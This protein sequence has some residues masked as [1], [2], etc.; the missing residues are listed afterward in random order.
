MSKA[1]FGTPDSSGITSDYPLNTLSGVCNKISVEHGFWEAS[2]NILEKI[3]L[4]HTELSEAAE[5]YRQ[6]NFNQAA[7]TEELADTL[8][9][10]FDLSGHMGLDLDKAVN[11]KIE[12][13]KAR[14]FLHGKSR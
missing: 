8:I 10:I 2:T 14:K 1:I 12:I 4:V 11:D 7:F 13:N 9:R 3:C 5:E 6:K